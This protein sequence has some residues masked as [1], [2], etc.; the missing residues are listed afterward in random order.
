MLALA[1]AAAHP[2]RAGALV[3]VGCGTFDEA[4]R[5]QYVATVEARRKDAAVRER[6]ERAAA[7]PDADARLAEF[8]AIMDSLSVYDALP[9]ELECGEVDADGHRETWDDMLRLQAEGVFPAAFSAV[10]SPVLML[11]GSYD[12]HPGALIRASLEPLLPQLEYREWEECGHYPWAE[13]AVRDEFF[14]VLRA[15]L[16]GKLGPG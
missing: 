15:W 12:P 14:A 1:Y 5:A 7:L 16:A 3:L 11:H 4:A 2:G 6:L 10:R 9:G 8:G 13:R